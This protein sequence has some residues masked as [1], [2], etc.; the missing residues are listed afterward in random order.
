MLLETIPEPTAVTIYFLLVQENR[1]LDISDRPMSLMWSLIDTDEDFS[2]VMGVKN[3]FNRCEIIAPVA[4]YY[5]GSGSDIWLLTSS[6]DGEDRQINSSGGA[7]ELLYSRLEAL[8]K[9]GRF[10]SPYDYE[11]ILLVEADEG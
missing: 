11:Y 4:E 10:D 8:F 6:L 3:E 9:A 2:V 7:C 1:V 5:T